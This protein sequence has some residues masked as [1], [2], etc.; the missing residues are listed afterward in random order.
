[1]KRHIFHSDVPFSFEAGGEL[2]ALEIVYYTSEHERAEG[3]KVIWIC[4]ALTGNADPSDWW[5][6]MVG[7][8]RLID[9]SR[10]YVVCV[11]MLCSAYGSPGP[12]SI[13]PATGRPY[14][15]SFPMTTIRDI[16]KANSLIRKHLGIAQIDLLIGPS[17]GGYQ[18]AEWAVMEA[19]VIKEVVLLATEVRISPYLTAYNESQRMALEADPTFRQAGSLED[20]RAGLECA[21]SIALISYRSYDG[22][23]R[24]QAETAQDAL[25][26][27]R[28]GSY[29]R[30]QGEK[31]VRRG[32][33][34]Y[35]YWYLTKALDSMNIGRA[36]GG[37]A[38]ALSRISA[39]CHVICIDSDCLFPPERGREIVSMIPGA[40]YHEIT[41]AFGHDGFLIENAQLCEIMKPWILR[42]VER[43]VRIS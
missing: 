31:L 12:R 8:G 10:Y 28:A 40:D 7:E 6:E 42:D 5:P 37:T 17:V 21:R 39:R 13:D 3:E 36:R 33:D 1:M 30:Y 15:F 11:N 25:F 34:A 18:A 32:F 2:P 16:V 43:D 27:D 4:H 35:S 24:T 26:A 19:G 9:T 38:A 14:F 41:S 20:G 23:C 29:Q 22:Y